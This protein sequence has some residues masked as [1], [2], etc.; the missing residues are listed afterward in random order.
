MPKY[1][2]SGRCSCG[3]EILD[4]FTIKLRDPQGMAIFNPIQR[5]RG[6]IVMQISKD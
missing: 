6:L 3:E 5:L 2:S 4:I 1:Q